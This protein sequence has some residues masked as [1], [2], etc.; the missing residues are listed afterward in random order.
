MQSVSTRFLAAQFLTFRLGSRSSCPPRHLLA[1]LSLRHPCQL[2]LML[3]HPNKGLTMKP[4]TIL[5]LLLCVAMAPAEELVKFDKY[6]V[7]DMIYDSEVSVAGGPVKNY[8][9]RFVIKDAEVQVI[10][11][12]AFI[13]GTHEV[14]VDVDGSNYS[15]MHIPISRVISMVGVGAPANLVE[16]GGILKAKIGYLLDSK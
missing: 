16:R 13:V 7:I 11:G 8:I 12:M 2:N 15:K 14:K 6:T 5:L 3:A 10:G 4:T 9:K 1:R